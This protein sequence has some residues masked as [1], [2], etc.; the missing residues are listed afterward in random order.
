ML[1]GRE[2]AMAAGRN[3]Y[4]PPK[5]ITGL[6][7]HYLQILDYWRGNV[8]AEDVLRAEAGSRWDQCET[9]FYVALERLA[10]GYRAGAR[11]HFQKAL[12]TG[13]FVFG[14]YQ[15]SRLFLKRMDQDPT[16]PTW[17]P[18]KE[19]ATQPATMLQK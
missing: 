9:H 2:A 6:S 4:T 11:D 14:E 16:W 10:Q 12:A 13:V 1:G 19:P 3:L 7:P 18:L 5:G 8:S 17:I 15:W